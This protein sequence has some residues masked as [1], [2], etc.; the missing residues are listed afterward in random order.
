MYEPCKKT[1]FYRDFPYLMRQLQKLTSCD[2]QM[3]LKIDQRPKW[4]PHFD[5]V[6]QEVSEFSDNF[7][8]LLGH[9][10]DTLSVNSRSFNTN[11]ISTFVRHHSVRAIHVPVL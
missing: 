1:C 5:A 11:L 3:F 6:Q 10:P 2:S 9:A 7:P 8:I 4:I